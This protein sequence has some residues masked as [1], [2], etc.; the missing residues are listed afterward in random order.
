MEYFLKVPCSIYYWSPFLL[1]KLAFYDSW[2]ILHQN[3][4]LIPS[5]IHLISWYT[6]T[7]PYTW[8]Y[9][10]GWASRF[11]RYWPSHHKRLALTGTLPITEKITSVKFGNKSRK[12]VSSSAESNWSW[13]DWFHHKEPYRWVLHLVHIRLV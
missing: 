6:H 3:H 13:Q 8:V 5:E 12:N 7:L 10:T 2:L 4:L 1:W 11:L 9:S